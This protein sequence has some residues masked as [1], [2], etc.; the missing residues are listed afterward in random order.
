M[1]SPFLFGHHAEQSA[2]NGLAKEINNN[3]MRFAAFLVLLPMFK[4]MVA[5]FHNSFH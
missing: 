4:C 5:A 3:K 1:I 2:T